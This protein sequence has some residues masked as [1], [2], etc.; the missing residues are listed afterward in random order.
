MEFHASDAF[1]V[2]C[3]H[4]IRPNSSCYEMK[5]ED[6]VHAVTVLSNEIRAIQRTVNAR[7]HD[8]LCPSFFGEAYGP[9]LKMIYT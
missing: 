5:S 6:G 7:A 4:V 9:G 1:P 2:L 8:F 3:L